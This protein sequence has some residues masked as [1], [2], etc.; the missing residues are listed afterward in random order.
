MEMPKLYT[1]EE[2]KEAMIVGIGLGGVEQ[3]PDAHA[4]IEQAMGVFR[5]AHGRPVPNYDTF[6]RLHE[7]RD[8]RGLAEAHLSAAHMASSE[9]APHAL[10][11]LAALGRELLDELAHIGGTVDSFDTALR[12][13]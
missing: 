10:I 1:D 6:K 2:I 11:A 5:G 7:E 13:R 9:A 12:A 8:W 4:K 3:H